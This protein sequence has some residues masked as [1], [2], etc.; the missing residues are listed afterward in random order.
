MTSPKTPGLPPAGV[1]W[2][3]VVATD[4]LVFVSGQVAW[5][6]SGQIVGQTAAE[7]AERAFLN[8]STA[9]EAAGSSIGRLVKVG[10]FLTSAAAIPEVRAVRDRWL[11]DVRPA[12]T[13]L[14]VA[15]LAQTGLLVEIEGIALPGR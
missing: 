10:L 15:E 5:D 4:G 1:G 7:Q 9:L 11:R 8:L 3:Q 6:P 13:L 2:S 12:S 14:V